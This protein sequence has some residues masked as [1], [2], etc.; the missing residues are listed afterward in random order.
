MSTISERGWRR[1]KDLA[2]GRVIDVWYAKDLGIAVKTRRGWY[3]GNGHRAALANMTDEPML[4]AP[5]VGPCR[6]AAEA[7]EAYTA[8]LSPR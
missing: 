2:D 4:C 8:A 3:A 6:T 7:I 5:S 1:R